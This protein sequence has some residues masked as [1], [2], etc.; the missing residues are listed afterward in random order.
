MKTAFKASTSG[1]KFSRAGVA[2]AALGLLVALPTL[3]HAQ[4]ANSSETYR[5]LNLFGD[6]FERV[7]AKYVDEIS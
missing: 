5:Q 1:W 2:A 7:R 4:T 3:A 6:V